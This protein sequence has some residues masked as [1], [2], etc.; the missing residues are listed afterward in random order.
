[1]VAQLIL[2][3]AGALVVL[4]ARTP[5]TVTFPWPAE[6]NYQRAVDGKPAHGPLA[7][8]PQGDDVWI[9]DGPSH[10]FLRVGPD[11]SVRV[12]VEA[13]GFAHS[14]VVRESGSIAWLDRAR[15][16]VLEVRPDG[17]VLLD[18]PLPP[19]LQH[20]RRIASTPDRLLIHT[21]YQETFTVPLGPDPGLTEWFLLKREGL[22][23]P[24]LPR[25]SAMVVAR[26]AML[27]MQ[28]LEAPQHPSEK[29]RVATGF[30]VDAPDGLAAEILGGD[31]RGW[32]VRVTI[33]T[34]GSARDRLLRLD[35]KG[36]V[37]WDADL[38][39]SG[40][41]SWADRLFVTPEGSIRQ[42]LA[43]DDGLLL[44]TWRTP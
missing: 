43:T 40:T 10:S 4:P 35:W 41:L 6:A 12:R 38:P 26:D 13:T 32:W 20:V 8:F 39:G 28:I 42:V 25:F 16:R 29:D 11:G 33:G 36:G 44:H 21:A 34:P 1:M 7:V 27:E 2:V 22:V 23:F 14:F 3:V 5:E 9:F 31:D 19:G 37:L 17:E 15:R 18:L 30:P 24:K